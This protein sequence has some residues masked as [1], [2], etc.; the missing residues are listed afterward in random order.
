MQIR[1]VHPEN[2]FVVEGEVV[3]ARSS[4]MGIRFL[5]TKELVAPLFLSD[6]VGA[7]K[8]NVS[9]E[10]LA[11]EL[12]IYNVQYRDQPEFQLEY[13]RNL[14]AGGLVVQ[15]PYP[16]AIGTKVEVRISVRSVPG[17]P[18]RLRGRVIAQFP[19]G[20]GVEIN[21]LQTV[22]ESLVRFAGLPE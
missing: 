10:K 22:R 13:N 1:I 2:G 17:Q 7:K 9:E 15:T 5:P 8:V 12:G 14:R 16:V 6:L 21:N 19:S 11:A 4:E 3:H 20:I 18:V